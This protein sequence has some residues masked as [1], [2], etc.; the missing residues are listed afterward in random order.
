MMNGQSSPNEPFPLAVNSDK[1]ISHHGFQITTRKLPI[2][3]AEP[4]DHMTAGLGIA[5]PEMIFGDNLV[6]IKH[7]RSGWK[8]E[9]NA[10]DALDLVDKTGSSMLQVA[11]S[12]EWQSTREKKHE[13]I[14]EVVKPFDWS[15]STNYKGTESSPKVLE[16][17]S[18]PIPFELLKRP[19]PIIFFDEVMLYEDEMADNG[20]TLLSCKLRVMPA[21]LLLLC[22]FFMRLD[23]V[24]LRIRDTRVYAEFE[25]GE[26]IREYT[27]REDKYEVVRQKLAMQGRDAPAQLRDPNSII[28]LLPIVDKSLELPYNRSFSISPSVSAEVAAS[29]Q[30]SPT[31]APSPST[32]NPTPHPYSPKT[33]ASTAA[34]SSPKG[35]AEAASKSGKHVPTS[36]KLAAE[37]RKRAT[38]VTETYIA[39]S[40]CEKLIKECA[41]QADYTIPQRLEK[42]GLVPKGVDGEDLGVG[43]G[44]WYEDL[45]LAPTFST[46]AQITFLHMYILTVRLRAFPAA[47]AP[48]WH[49]HLLDHFFYSAED[50]LVREHNIQARSL[51]NKYLK[52]LFTQ[53]RGLLAGY[54]E[55]L[56]KGD[57][58]LATAVWRNVFGGKED[59]DLMGLGEVVS[60]MRGVLKGLDGMEDEVVADGEIQFGDPRTQR[61]VVEIKSKLMDSLPKEHGSPLKE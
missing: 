44:W 21:R 17:S 61:K 28:D 18:T 55:G 58:V 8:I 45:G 32:K 50:R 5:P 34:A 16:P 37:V 31:A 20:I 60:Y 23:G 40:I 46:W 2:L 52:D 39:Y 41:T 43:K 12:R 57:A 33:P 51:R 13:G 6:S 3:K 1:T 47:H 56:V 27:A 25:S 54:D 4:I 15:Y 9:F 35:S 11:H 38:S 49:Q 42:N 24:M 36:I 22:R 29:K 7:V 30:A 48:S 53:W 10:F 26:I 14:T 19:D 59:V